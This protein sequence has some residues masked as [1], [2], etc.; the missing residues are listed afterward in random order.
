MCT[1]II[2]FFSCLF[3]EKA[4]FTVNRHDVSTCSRKQAVFMHC[5]AHTEGTKPDDEFNNAK[6]DKLN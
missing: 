3:P 5:Y 1:I 2:Q 6:S 4:L